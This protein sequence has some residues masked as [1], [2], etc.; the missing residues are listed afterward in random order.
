[1][2]DWLP[3]LAPVNPWTDATY[4]ML[5]GIFCRDIRDHDLRY[6]GNNV[7]FF[8]ELEDGKEKIFWHL[9]TREI[10]R[11][12]IPRRKRKFYSVGQIYIE[13]ERLPDL[14][15]CERLPWVKPLVEHPTDPEVLAWDY[16][17][18]D[19]T[20]KTYVWVRNYDFVVIMKKYPDGQRRLITSFYVDEEYKPEDFERKY[21]NRI[22]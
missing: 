4:E 9:T 1:M 5:Y 2:P 17:E 6:F 12:R 10:K 8:R 7:W 15:R 16:E 21:A 19:R 18:G 3:E 22:K 13:P 14:R 20:I 11:K